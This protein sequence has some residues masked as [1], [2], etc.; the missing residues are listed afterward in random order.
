MKRELSTMQGLRALGLMMAALAG[1]TLMM[2]ACRSIPAGT[3]PTGPI[4]VAPPVSTAPLTTNAA[5]DY[6]VTSLMTRCPEIGGA[7]GNPPSVANRFHVADRAVNSLPM[8][9]WQ[10][11]I[12][13]R[14]VR[15]ALPDDPGVAFHLESSLR[16]D[17]AL[18]TVDSGEAVYHWQMRLEQPGTEP[19]RECWRQEVIVAVPM[20]IPP[21]AEPVLDKPAP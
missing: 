6:M 7:G 10:S 18:A 2:P 19:P 9:V 1:L 8:E 3:P 17:A 15:A 21:K 5:V 4:V 14:V 20:E 13:M 16:R 11:L 12:R